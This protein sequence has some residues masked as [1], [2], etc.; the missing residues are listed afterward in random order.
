MRRR[1]PR[2]ASP[3]IL[4]RSEATSRSRLPRHPLCSV[5]A[6][7]SFTA[8]SRAFSAWRASNCRAAAAARL[9]LHARRRLGEHLFS[10]SFLARAA[11][12][13]RRG[14]RRT[15]TPRRRCFSGTTILRKSPAAAC[16]A[17]CSPSARLP[18]SGVRAAWSGAFAAES[19]WRGAASSPAASPRAARRRLDARGRA[20]L[21][22]P[23]DVRRPLPPRSS[24]SSSAA[25][26]GAARGEVPP[27]AAPSATTLRPLRDE[28][29]DVA[30]PRGDAN[31]PRAAAARAVVFGDDVARPSL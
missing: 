11:A 3:F 17:A 1:P 29:A 9:R 21:L 23:L 31:A 7:R 24:A 22:A 4:A 19:F 30:R 26:F 2:P 15:P 25:V 6:P 8:C 18:S 20:L 13:R 12:P 28:I 10:S 14:R 5:T 27:P 16:P